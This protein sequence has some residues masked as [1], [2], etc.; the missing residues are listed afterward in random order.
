MLIT[1]ISI[2][3][4]FTIITYL[5]LYI[6]YKFWILQPVFHFYDIYFWFINKGIIRHE[7][8]KQ[9]KYVN[10]KNII[11]LSSEQLNL[12]NLNNKKNNTIEQT[13]NKKL[14]DD[15]ISLIQIHYLNQK[16]NENKYYPKSNNIIPYFQN[17]NNECY[18]SF[19]KKQQSFHNTKTENIIN[20]DIIIG[21]I[22]SRPLHV[23]IKKSTNNKLMIF[24]V[25][26]VDYLCV[27]KFWRKQNIA[28]QLIQTHE[29]IQSHQNQKICV[30]LFKRE[31]ELTGI[32]PLTIYKSYCFDMKTWGK[33]KL[34]P[35]NIKLLTGDK[36]NIFY[37]IESLKN[38]TNIDILIYP[39]LTNI[40]ELINTKNIFIKILMINH[41][42][43]AIYIFKKTC[44]YIKKNAE[45]LSCISS[46]YMTSSSLYDINSISSMSTSVS[47]SSKLTTKLKSNINQ[48]EYIQGFKLALWS[49]IKKN[50]NFEYLL[51]E[52][53]GD[54]Y[55]IINDIC[56]HRYPLTISP[57]AFFFYNFAYAPFMSQ[58]CVIIY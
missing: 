34:L 58:K 17:H 1:L 38:E 33:P 57:M 8:P 16:G 26:Y 52:D 56:K 40:I 25:Y 54:N 7:L 21:A 24:D 27:D 2:L 31:E 22:T 3:V 12:M 23:I 39:E 5:L 37:I 6:K 14:L 43:C 36:E 49:I 53:I 30:S 11:T 13:K 10:T 32:V 15:F 41:N 45:I 9:N 55:L 35:S 46:I 51:M 48:D 19:Y 47:V 28:P 4:L 50:Q 20:D 29:Y 42:I 18:F 44:T